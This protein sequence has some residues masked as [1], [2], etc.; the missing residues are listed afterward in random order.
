MISSKTSYSKQFKMFLICGHLQLTL[1]CGLLTV[2]GT[3]QLKYTLLQVTSALTCYRL[4]LGFSFCNKGR[5][6]VFPCARTSCGAVVKKKSEIRSVTADFINDQLDKLFS[7]SCVH[8]LS[9]Q[10][11]GEG[12][13]LSHALTV[14][15]SFRLHTIFIKD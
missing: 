9:S 12:S 11:V 8:H 2:P 10:A 7:L 14:L 1:L 3:E 4:L 15:S 13:I 5:E 6:N